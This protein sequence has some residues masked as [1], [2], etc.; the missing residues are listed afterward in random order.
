MAKLKKGQPRQQEQQ[1]PFDATFKAWVKEQARDVLPLLLPGAIYIEALDVERI[2]PTM[3]VDRVFK[4]LYTGKEY[5]L[6]I[7]FESG[8]D[9]DMPVRLLVYNALLYYEHG[10][11]VVSI[12]V[13]PFRAKIA[14][15]PLRV[16]KGEQD[17]LV[18]HFLTLPLFE[19]NA[20]YYVR[21]HIL[22]MYP[23]LPTMQGTDHVLMKQAVEELAA[24]YQY[25]EATLAEQFVWMELL[26]ERTDTI[27]PQEKDEIW[28]ELKM[29]DKL[30]EESPRIQ[31]IRAESEAEGEVRAAQRMLI[32]YVKLRFPALVELAQEELSRINSL[33]TLDLLAQKVYTAP[34]EAAVRWLL[35]PS[36]A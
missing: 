36:A 29:Y 32:S 4:V 1:Q 14:E 28:R 15:S 33:E 13:Y 22:C 7:E 35:T 24:R 3:R 19:L 30:W 6:H 27:S 34:D 18:F 23:L 20:E 9:N 5:I 12:I 2:K 25:D 16:I 17:L 8:A 31:K 26:L 11:P 21:E 10:L